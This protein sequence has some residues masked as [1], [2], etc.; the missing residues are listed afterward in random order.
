ME[1]GGKRVSIDIKV[2]DS[3]L[4]YNLLLG[5]SW[6]YAM[7][8]VSSSIF[9]LIQ[10]PHHGKIVTI[11]QLDFC[12]PNLC[13]QHTNI[14]PF[15]EGSNISYES[16]GVGLLKY[17]SLMGTFPLSTLNPPPK[18]STVNTISTL[19]QKYLGSYD[20][21]VVPSLITSSLPVSQDPIPLTSSS[22]GEHLTTSNHKIWRTK[23]KGGG[24]RKR[25][26]NKKDPT[27]R[28][29]VG[30]HP[31]SASGHHLGHHPPSNSINHVGGKVPTSSH[32]DGKKLANGYHAET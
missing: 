12:T 32:H 14:V 22:P 16:V 21:R 15:V 24:R 29:H 27:S 2:F 31:P 11:N 30:H 19:S 8:T 1:L 10:F 9:R 6:F 17:S 20:P 18:V 23:R 3:P 25:N 7:T 13:G 26:L 4:D 28:H 5:S